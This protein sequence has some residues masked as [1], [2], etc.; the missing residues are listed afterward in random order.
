[1]NYL[2]ILLSLTYAYHL[3]LRERSAK[4]LIFYK[5]PHIVRNDT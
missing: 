5:I 3:D 1:M 4:V 2:K